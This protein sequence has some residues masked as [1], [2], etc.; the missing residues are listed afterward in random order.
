MNR[1]LTPLL[2]CCLVCIGNTQTNPKIAIFDPTAVSVS[3][4][5]GAKDAIRELISSTVVNSKRY[6]VLERVF[7][8]KILQEQ[9]FSHS[10]M[11]DDKDAVAIGKLAGAEK[12][13]LSVLTPSSEKIEKILFTVKLLN[14]ET[15]SVEYQQ[16]YYARDITDL[17]KN[18]QAMISKFCNAIDLYEGEEKNGKPHG[19]GVMKNKEG[20]YSGTWVNGLRHGRG[21]M[22]WGS[23]YYE[24]DWFNDKEHGNGVKRYGNGNE[25]NG[26]WEHGKESGRGVLS[27][28]NGNRFEGEFLNGKPV[29][30]ELILP[31]GNRYEGTFNEF[32][33]TFPK[34]RGNVG[35]MKYVNGNRFEGRFYPS[36]L[37]CGVM[38]YLDG[39]RYEGNL[40]NDRRVHYQREWDIDGG[41][42]YYYDNSPATMYYPNGDTY[43]GYWKNDKRDG[44][45]VMIWSDGS[46]YEGHWKDDVMHGCGKMVSPKGKEK[47]GYWS[48]G[49]KVSRKCN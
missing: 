13:L 2:A 36:G 43:K 11:V 6:T 18:L 41:V 27:Y 29:R 22:D 45:G 42:S 31:N 44:E 3:L 32:D 15:S 14:I 49:V 33:G 9:A 17:M 21:K 24:G 1:I 46:R 30:G 10:S 39:G 37:R 12:V 4:G 38:F 35:V 40:V 47:A 5:S 19:Q 34:E 28:K 23:R 16:V 20:V 7:L 25:Y 8:E 26:E 48:N